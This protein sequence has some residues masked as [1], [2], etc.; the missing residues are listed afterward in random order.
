MFFEVSLLNK[1]YLVVYCAGTRH[2]FSHFNSLGQSRNKAN[3]CIYNATT[4]AT[5]R[6]DAE[7]DTNDIFQVASPL[8]L[9]FMRHICQKYV[10][11]TPIT[12]IFFA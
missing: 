4:V 6:Y 8:R 3:C 5:D 7:L 1:M 9:F 2:Y 12:N 10:L 11:V